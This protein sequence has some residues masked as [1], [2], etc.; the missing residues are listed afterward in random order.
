M[1]MKKVL[2][3]VLC[4]VLLMGS[5]ITPNAA[6]DTKFWSVYHSKGAPSNEGKLLS[7]ATMQISSSNKVAVYMNEYSLNKTSIK[8]YR[9]GYADQGKYLLHLLLLFPQREPL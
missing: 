9:S 2:A 5:T 3:G 6:V 7:T 4:G 1:K 8:T